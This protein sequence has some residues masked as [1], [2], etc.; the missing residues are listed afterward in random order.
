MTESDDRLGIDR[1]ET[2]VGEQEDEE[3][4]PPEDNGKI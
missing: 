2:D 1:S 3:S 4:N